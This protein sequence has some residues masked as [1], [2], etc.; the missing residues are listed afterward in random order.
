MT[1]QADRLSAA[2]SGRYR[3]ERELGA[4]GMATVYLAE[5]LKHDRKVAIKVLKP[6][7]AAVLGAERFVVEIKTTAAMSHPHILPLFD[8][9]TA[10]G[11]L[12]YVMPF[13]EGE[14]IRDRLNRETQLG[15]DEAVRIAREVADALD[16]A[17]RHGVI[18]RDIK[19]E[20]ILLHDGRA[21]VM[22][23][24]IALAVSAAAGGRMTET[25]LSLGT[26]HYMSP[27][28]ATAEK[29]I[30]GR[31]DQ[32]SLASVLYEMLAGVPPHEGGSA[33]QTIMRIITEAAR[34]VNE[35]RKN[36]PGNVSAALAK[37]LEKLPADRFESAKAFADALA[38]LSFTSTASATTARSLTG[39]AGRPVAL[40]AA[41]IVT[42]VLAAWGWLRTEASEPPSA[43]RTTLT[44]PDTIRLYEGLDIS[45]DG[46]V[47]VFGGTPRRDPIMI[48]RAGSDGFAPIPGTAGHAWPALSP[49]GRQVAFVAS[50]AKDGLR[51]SSIDGGTPTRIGPAL[52]GSP[53]AWQGDRAVVIS[54]PSGLVRVA[55][56]G[57]GT[58]NITTLDS[59]AREGYH[60]GPAPLPGGGI[61]FITFP[62]GNI[63]A[64]A[65]KVAV[66]AAGS[67]RHTVLMPGRQVRFAPPGHLLVVRADGSLVAVPFDAKALRVTG[68]PVTLL[69][70]LRVGI[71]ATA[72][73]FAVSSTGRLVVVTRG[74]AGAEPS[75][76]V[77]ATRGGSVTPVMPGWVEPFESVALSRDGR[78]IAAGYYT[79]DGEEVE[80]RDLFSGAVQRITVPGAQLRTLAFDPTGQWLYFGGLGPGRYGLYRASLS[81]SGTAS[82]WLATAD[83]VAPLYPNFSPDGQTLIYTQFMPSGASEILAR[84][85]GDPV[86]AGTVLVAD[87]TTPAVSQDGKW[88]A[89]TAVE[90]SAAA[91]WVRSTDPARSERWQISSGV[92]LK[93]Y[94]TRWSAGGR[95]LVFMGTDS[96]WA[97]SVSGGAT[98]SVGTR[99]GLAGSAPYSG[100][101]DVFSNGDLLLQRYRRGGGATELTMIE[102]WRAALVRARE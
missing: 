60:F 65:G 48:R 40:L 76:F 46:S 28:Q 71:F 101:F 91:I 3:I 86:G 81:R 17:H 13:I 14:T 30:T 83:M 11:F 89:Y 93:S 82:R 33:Q 95:E 57:G 22:D 4:G 38:N 96:I 90:R 70:G 24:G 29:E 32:Y 56:A 84:P 74:A 68:E 78:A 87:G 26:P 9:G 88:M 59:T 37:A 102:D 39:P 52:Y 10:D 47:V 27:E 73:Q 85:V 77:R 20:N 80:V 7:L 25:G 18:H 64:A 92:T 69:S 75:E 19:P 99:R 44:L 15:V 53:I 5:D 36:V 43:W 61:A 51:V 6:E 100:N 21:M 63:S 23:F 79:D 34:P 98:F 67:N 41:L 50:G 94:T 72:G 35:F 97:T 2:L 8:S 54:A 16:Y 58:E 66:A 49:D 45:A 31:S 62:V 42:A 55:T 12:F 1:S